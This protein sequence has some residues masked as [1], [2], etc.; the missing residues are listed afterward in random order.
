LL[1]AAPNLQLQDII[2]AIPGVIYQ[3]VYR[4]GEMWVAYMSDRIYEITGL[5]AQQIMQDLT[6][7]DAQIHPD[8]RDGYFASMM[9][10]IQQQTEWRCEW[11]FFHTNGQVRWISGHSVPTVYDAN[12][13]VFHGVLL[14]I[15]DRK[16]TEAALAESEMKFRAIIEN[17]TECF[18]IANEIGE[19][20]YLSPQFTKILGYDTSEWLHQSIVPLIHPDDLLNWIE[21]LQNVSLFGEKQTVEYRMRHQDGSW[22][23]EVAT[24]SPLRNAMGEIIG[25]VGVGRDVTEQKRAELAL[26]KRTKVL[27]RTLQELQQTQSQLIQSEKMSSLGQLVAGITHEI[28]NPN[29]FIAGNLVYLNRY[30]SDLLDLVECYRQHWIEPPPLVQEKVNQV[31]LG[32]LA[33]DLPKVLDSMTIGTE[34][35]QNIIF[36]LQSFACMD[37]SEYKAANLHRNLDHTLVIL[38][39]RLKHTFYR[40]N[41]RVVKEY[42]DLPLINCYPGD[43]NQVLMNIL[44]NAIDAIDSLYPN[45]PPLYQYLEVPPAQ[46]IACPLL[47]PMIWLTTTRLDQNT[48][49]IRIR[50]NGPLI[51]EVAQSRLFDPFFTTKPVGK[52][53]G[54][55]LAIGYQIITE[56]HHGRLTCHSSDEN[57]VEFVIQLPLR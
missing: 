1:S 11:R 29:N 17:A 46:A 13:I 8:D 24:A 53:T 14:D 35:I 50:N 25:C 9:Q 49:A 56:K 21:S 5:M 32:F 41:I 27:E 26:Q 7:I 51:P 54:M 57:G 33:K 43:L 20:T 52:A 23:W 2:Q 34:R 37:E 6:V 40:P 19:I 30:V 12:H 45:E 38:E 44:N 10:A 4:D 28:N 22:R 42:G 15:T 16:Q 31:D 18:Y 55:G 3:L 48:I 39:H 36:S 47:E